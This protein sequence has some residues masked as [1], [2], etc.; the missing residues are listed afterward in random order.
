MGKDYAEPFEAPKPLVY[1][2]ELRKAVKK[3]LKANG[4]GRSAICVWRGS[5]A[6][7]IPAKEKWVARGVLFFMIF[8]MLLL[9]ASILVIQFID[10][11]DGK[12]PLDSAGLLAAINAAIA[13]ATGLGVFLA[14][15]HKFSDPI[16]VTTTWLLIN[17]GPVM[18]VMLYN[19][20]L[21]Y[22]FFEFTRRMDI[23]LAMIG[24][25]AA[26]A[27][28][29]MSAAFSTLRWT[30]IERIQ[31]DYPTVRPF[32]DEIRFREAP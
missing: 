32:V 17:L 23:I 18:L 2:R 15:S 16:E 29:V 9:T 24:W 10:L 30:S 25:I 5:N 3:D 19:M 31:S 7:D 21:V 6:R 13:G 20:I 22:G 28:S 11:R 27:T 26:A 1:S 14:R 4:I 8:A 12:P